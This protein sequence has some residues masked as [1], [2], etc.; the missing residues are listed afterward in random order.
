LNCAGNEQLH[1]AKLVCVAVRAVVSAG[2]V[3]ECQWRPVVIGCKAQNVVNPQKRDDG[4]VLAAQGELPELLALEAD[5]NL[6]VVKPCVITSGA[7]C[8]V[9]ACFQGKDGAEVI[10]DFLTAP[11]TQ[12]GGGSCGIADAGFPFAGS[13]GVAGVTHADIR[14][15]INGDAGFRLGP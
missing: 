5:K 8:R 6:A 11:E 9:D 13:I 12:P 3:D 1:I 7:C 10:V 14:D 15:A 2:V 4:R